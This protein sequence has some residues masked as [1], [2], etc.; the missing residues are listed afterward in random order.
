M[1]KHS[2]ATRK[3]R[4]VS[5]L[6]YVPLA[7]G[8]S[9]VLEAETFDNLRSL[10][11]TDQW[12]ASSN[13]YGQSYVRCKGP[14]SSSGSVTVARLITMAGRGQVVRY[15]DGDRTNLRRSNLYLSNG[16]ARDRDRAVLNELAAA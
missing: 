14:G 2:R 13:G 4:A 5:R 8:Q 12:T 15:R 7:N 10:G 16:R 3:D 1:Q 11:L 6:V 9:A